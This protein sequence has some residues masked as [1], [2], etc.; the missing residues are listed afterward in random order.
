LRQLF[1]PDRSSERSFVRGQSN[2]PFADN[3][4]ILVGAAQEHG[5]SYRSIGDA[6]I[7]EDIVEATFL[8]KSRDYDCPFMIEE[9]NAEK[10]SPCEF[11]RSFE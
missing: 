7:H 1:L 11:I 5:A 2:D 3:A 8:Q 9:R 6:L 10:S 4:V